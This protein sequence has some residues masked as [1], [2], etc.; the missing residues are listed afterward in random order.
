[1]TWKEY[2]DYAESILKNPTPTAPYDDPE[3]MEYTKMNAA[4][5]H[6]WLKTAPLLPNTQAFIPTISQPQ[7][8]VLIT[9]PWCGDA[10]HITPIVY[11]MSTL[12]D[13][14][15]L[16]I[17]LRDTDSEIENYLTHGTKSIPVLIVRDEHGKDLFHWSS[18][19]AAA[20]KVYIDLKAQQVPVEEIKMAIQKFYNDDKAVAIQEEIMTL[21]KQY[22]Q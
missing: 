20:Q 17:Q 2:L 7:Q 5:T 12:N 16:D 13:K 3:Y 1:M 21:L 8:W 22:S 9:E 15:S 19:P 11:L 14:I 10:A 4:R 18:R 6:R